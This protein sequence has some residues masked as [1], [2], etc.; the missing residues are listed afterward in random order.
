MLESNFCSF[1]TI[2]QLARGWVGG[3]GWGELKL[4]LTQPQAELELW[5]ELDNKTKLGE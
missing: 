3:G 1:P 4:K 2:S 5:A